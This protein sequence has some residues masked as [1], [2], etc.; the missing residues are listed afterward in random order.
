MKK[1]T[2]ALRI[3]LLAATTA[4]ALS[5]QEGNETEGSMNPDYL[6]ILWADEEQQDPIFIPLDL[7]GDLNLTTPETVDLSHLPMTEAQQDQLRAFLAFQLETPEGC[8]PG[9]FGF[10]PL[11]YPPE[12]LSLSQMLRR[13][14][15]VVTGIVRNIVPGWSPGIGTPVTLIQFEVGEVLRDTDGIATPGQLFVYLK[16]P[17]DEPGF[18]GRQMCPRRTDEVQ[19]RKG[20][21]FLAFGFGGR[22]G[23]DDDRI[24]VTLFEIRD[25][26]LFANPLHMSLKASESGPIPLW[27]LP[28]QMEH[29]GALSP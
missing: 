27:V 18:G 11:P 9:P 6:R 26:F 5:A 10:V 2:A 21:H 24:S 4:L 12:R 1:L 23:G 19:P 20:S 16:E 22:E 29:L 3:C 7:I 15:L 13:R 14:R 17:G 28:E 8:I 25:S